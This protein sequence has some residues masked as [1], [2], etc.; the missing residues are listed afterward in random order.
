[1]RSFIFYSLCSIFLFS[2]IATKKSTQSI[3]NQ[4][5][6][7]DILQ[8]EKIVTPENGVAVLKK[9]PFKI[10]VTFFNNHDNVT[11]AFAFDR[12]FYD[13]PD[14]V[15]M[16]ECDYNT[17][18]GP[19]KFLD[20]KSMAEYNFNEKKRIIICDESRICHWFYDKEMDWH[21]FDKGVIVEDKKIIATK[22]VEAVRLPETKENISVADLSKDIYMVFATQAEQTE[23][24]KANNQPA[25]EAQRYKLILKFE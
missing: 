13:T 6:K 17:Y 21:R 1:M 2:C 5:F 10:Q 20:G 23:E 12:Y 24:E 25:K 11:A 4:K 15:N 7:I 8:D 19:C 3:L 14:E 9:H 22:T 18:E 16:W